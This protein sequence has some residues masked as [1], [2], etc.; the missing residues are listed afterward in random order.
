LGKRQE[1]RDQKYRRG[2]SKNSYGGEHLKIDRQP[3]KSFP[4]PRFL[5]PVVKSW[6]FQL[7]ALNSIH[8]ETAAGSRSIAAGAI[9][10]GGISRCLIVLWTHA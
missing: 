8:K 10:F 9:E 5:F 1:R 6:H 2:C 7:R 3:L 4:V